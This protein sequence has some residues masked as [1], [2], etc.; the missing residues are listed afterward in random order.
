MEDGL[1]CLFLVVQH[2]MPPQQTFRMTIQHV[3]G[4]FRINDSISVKKGKS[5]RTLNL[6]E[7]DDNYKDKCLPL[8]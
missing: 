3:M 8:A 7:R 6:E 5:F 2:S 4:S 1:S